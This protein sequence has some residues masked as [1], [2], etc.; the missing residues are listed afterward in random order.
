MNKFSLHENLSD[1]NQI[2]YR[3][4]KLFLKNVE[5]DFWDTKIEELLLLSNKL[6]RDINIST[7]EFKI[8]FDFLLPINSDKSKYFLDVFYKIN[9]KFSLSK[10]KVDILT[11]LNLKINKWQIIGIN[12]D[13][14]IWLQNWTWLV[15]QHI[16]DN[17]EYI[18]VLR[19]WY[20]YLVDNWW[21]LLYW[22]ISVSNINHLNWK[23][24][25][26]TIDG[27]SEIIDSSWNR[28]F[29]DSSDDLESIWIMISWNNTY[30]VVWQKDNN[31]NWDFTE[32]F[33]LDWFWKSLFWWLFNKIYW[34]DSDFD[35]KEYV[36]WCKDTSISYYDLDWNKVYI[37]EG[38]TVKQVWFIKNDFL[39]QALVYWI[40]SDFS[41]CLIN[42]EWY[43][44]FTWQPWLELWE[45]FYKDTDGIIYIWYYNSYEDISYFDINWNKGPT[46]REY[47]FLPFK[48]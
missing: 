2:I 1:T 42:K 45:W 3:D 19:N 5:N 34:I 38:F 11:N 30:H 35:S 31:L 36:Y 20:E 46:Y 44:F 28:V 8:L 7:K 18:V 29:Q 17:D 48:L 10:Y 37:K 22:W 9:Q 39:T 15:L 6:F 32:F 16:Q 41:P 27:K 23:I 24:Y 14:Y 43:S 47:N 26:C 4:F 33:I 12:G 21:N 40:N 13:D 25:I